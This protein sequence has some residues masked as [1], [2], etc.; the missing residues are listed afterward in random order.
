MVL[1]LEELNLGKRLMAEQYPHIAVKQAQVIQSGGIKTIWKLETSAGTVCLK[2]IRKS[3]GVVKFT[4]AAQEFLYQKG[5]NVA[6]IIPTKDGQLYFVHE[7]YGLVLYAWVIG[8]DLEMDR[9]PEH[10]YTGLK[11]LAQ[12]HKDTV[13][14]VPPDDC[15][16]YDRM[17]VW[18]SH[19]SKMSEELAAWKAAAQKGGTPFH[20]AYVKTADTMINMANHAVKLLEASCYAR[21]NN[22]I[23]KFGYMCHQDYGKG[24]ALRTDS[25]VCVL[26]LDNLTYDIPL[27]DIR[28]LI[29]KR[30]EELGR[31]DAE[32]LKRCMSYYEA[33]LPFTPEQMQVLY[34]DLL[35]PHKHYGYV[36]SPFKK[37]EAGDLKKLNEIL[38][39]EMAKLPMLKGL[40][41]GF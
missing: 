23:G 37:G 34:I 5:A 41:K 29:A 14:F 2:R 11:G 20:Q 21:W 25:G 31:W 6:E 7:G 17:G 38:Q 9:I 22:E 26:D 30:M 24:N 10:L 28:K 3:I 18:P 4:T 35:F 33:V 27:R 12:F 15:E 32:E 36:K 8:S 1:N 19:F 16:I 39:F 13:G 40:I